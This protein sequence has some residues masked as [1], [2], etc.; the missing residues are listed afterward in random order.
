MVD[1]CSGEPVTHLPE[2]VGYV[3]DLL[4]GF[5]SRWFLCGGWAADDWLGR[6]TR[7]HGDV[8]IAVFHHDQRAIFEHLR[9]WALVGHDPNVPDDT[10]EPWNGRRLDLPAHI[11]AP[12][13]GSPLSISTAATHSAFEFEFLLIEG[14]GDD[15]VLNRE[16]QIVL[17]LDRAT[18]PSAWG[19]RTVAPEVALFYKAGGDLP[20]A[21]AAGDGIRARD[22]Q[23]FTALLP[24]LSE[25]Q[26]RWL[27][28]SLA[29][30]R[31][32]HPWLPRLAS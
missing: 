14:T 4:L 9:G 18:R 8:D 16:R 24:T 13:L 20:A 15:W 22:E 5:G 28:E 12:V 30:V 31:G 17:P 21:W 7:E 27:R 2:A 10:T 11:H 26:R 23:D 6:Q 19:L 3:R 32:E 29:A 25:A 1:L